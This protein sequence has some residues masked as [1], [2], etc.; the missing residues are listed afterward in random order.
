MAADPRPVRDPRQRGHAPAD[1]GGAR[2]PAL[3]RLARA[4]AHCRGARIGVSGRRHPRVAG[5]RLQ[6][7]RAEPPSRGVPCCARR[8]ARR[9]HGA[10]GCR[11][12]YVGGRPL[13][14]VRRG[15]APCGRQRRA[16]STTHGRRLRLGRRPGADGPRRD[17]LPRSDSSMRDVSARHRLPVARHSRRARA[18]AKSVRRL[19][20]TTTR[21]DSAARRSTSR[22][23]STRSTTRPCARSS[24][25]DWS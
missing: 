11:P 12:V 4:L 25:T 13:L 23:S 1:P 19:L 22:A 8:L 6:P 10:A 24:A 2:R 18:E 16:R 7:S 14:R 20:S 9:P 15:R 17:G 21:H 5:A 3:R